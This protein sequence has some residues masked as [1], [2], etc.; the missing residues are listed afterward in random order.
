MDMNEVKKAAAKYPEEILP[1]F[2]DFVDI[3]GFEGVCALSKAFYG[4][5]IYIPGEKRIF[6]GCIYRTI[7]DQFDGFNYRTL[8]ERFDYGERTIRRYVSK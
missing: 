5:T 6:G 4:A 7:I 1:P 3:I 2:G 8:G